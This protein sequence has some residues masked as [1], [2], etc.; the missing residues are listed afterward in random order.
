MELARN[1]HPSVRQFIIMA[2]FIK[3]V[4]NQL[5]DFFCR[6]CF[7][8]SHA[9]VRFS[10]GVSDNFFESTEINHRKPC[11]LSASVYGVPEYHRAIIMIFTSA[12]LPCC[13]R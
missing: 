10:G 11:T 2:R 7:N 5:F 4:L 3:V 1:N 9:N 12:S 8:N 13:K 6:R